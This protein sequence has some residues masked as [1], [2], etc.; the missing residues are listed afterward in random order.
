MKEHR[1]E[2]TPVRVAVRIRPLFVDEIMQHQQTCVRL[3]GEGLQ[4]QVLLGKDR[5]FMF[6]YAF[7][8]SEAQR[9]IFNTCVHPLVTAFL[10]GYNATVFAYGQ[11]GTGKTFT[12]GAKTTRLASEDIGMIPRAIE[13]IFQ[14]IENNDN[15][16]CSLAVSYIEVYMEEL[17]DLLD[18]NTIKKD[19]FVRQDKHGNTILFGAKQCPVQTKEE[20]LNLLEAGS[21]VRHTAST[22]FQEH[23]SR[24]H[25]I[26]SLVLTQQHLHSQCT[27][28]G[29]ILSKQIIT[30]KFHF[31][32]L[33]G[34][35]R[36]EM[37]SNTQERFKECIK[38]NSGLLALGNVISALGDPKRRGTHVPFRDSKITRILKDSLGGNT[39][40]LMIACISP[41]SGD[42]SETVNVLKY[43]DRAKKIQNTPVVT[44]NDEQE[45]LK[46]A[47]QQV[48]TLRDA[49]KK[50]KSV[51]AQR[52]SSS[53]I[54]LENKC[55]RLSQLEEKAPNKQ[56]DYKHFLECTDE[57]YHLMLDLRRA[58]NL[59]PEQTAR[60]RD[61]IELAEEF[62]EDPATGSEPDS[63]I[64]SAG[65]Q[66][67]WNTAMLKLQQE[68]KDR[69]DTLAA[70]EEVFHKKAEE[71]EKLKGRVRAQEEENKESLAALEDAMERYKQQ[72]HRLLEQQIIMEEL[73][74]NQSKCLK[75]G[76]EIENNANDPASSELSA[77]PSSDR[78]FAPE[79]PNFNSNSAKSSSHLA[80]SSPSIPSLEG[81][82]ARF[83]SRSAI[84]LQKF[85]EDDEVLIHQLS[86]DKSD[87]DMEMPGVS[88]GR[89]SS[90]SKDCS[91][92]PVVSHRN[93]LNQTW[94]FKQYPHRSRGLH[95]TT[96]PKGEATLP[97]PDLSNAEFPLMLDDQRQSQGVKE[98]HGC[99]NSL[100]TKRQH[101]RASEL[102]L[103]QA[104]QRMRQLA[105]NIRMKE[106]LINQ[107]VQTKNV[108]NMP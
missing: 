71:I 80:H 77:R 66:L 103:G 53:Q 32:D 38:I 47:L 31:V 4:T 45:Q 84:L 56:E 16:E 52:N 23:S 50:G 78:L 102:R 10:K 11:T 98:R 43:A 25:A 29:K 87:G 94:T 106:Q 107:L 15:T 1:M 59:M 67:Q 60:I 24:S 90:S 5:A 13:E 92:A 26:F 68:L 82:M 41:A 17:R 70:H 12:I 101:L 91:A 37:A 30:S 33:A 14:R 72:S 65:E 58:S 44:Y 61:W 104:Q 95:G 8:P 69:Q 105:I 27:K 36:V 55:I 100:Q 89:T 79:H 34:S 19:I 76:T 2:E 83:R 96:M 86:D 54:L 49:L 97:R 88:M 21:T 73:R 40:T 108:F 28:E 42:F 93:S 63:G 3:V 46:D 64:Q 75:C 48:E 51:S 62:R 35:E 7:G 6:D 81:I 99:Q 18:L 85:E 57:A 20:L 74:A 39:K 9:D 22:L